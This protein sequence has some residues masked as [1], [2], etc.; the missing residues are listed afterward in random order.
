[1]YFVDMI[2]ISNKLTLSKGDHPAS[3]NQM[4]VDLMQSDESL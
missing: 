1:M 3:C 4:R 2:N